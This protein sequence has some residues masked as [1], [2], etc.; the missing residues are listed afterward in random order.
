MVVV[1]GGVIVVGGDVCG[2]D[3]ERDI[4]VMRHGQGIRWRRWRRGRR[5]KG[6]EVGEQRDLR[7]GR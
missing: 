4:R 3:G 2:L 7:I 1:E 6:G 5:G